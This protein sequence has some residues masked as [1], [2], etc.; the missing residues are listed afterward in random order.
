MRMELVAPNEEQRIRR[1]RSTNVDRL[2]SRTQEILGAEA[3]PIAPTNSGWSTDQ[4]ND[5]AWSS[6]NTT[7]SYEIGQ[8]GSENQGYSASIE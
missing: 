2:N 7:A 8:T 5:E 6:K 4:A 1:G 3:Q